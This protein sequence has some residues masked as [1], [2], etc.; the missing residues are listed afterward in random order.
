MLAFSLDADSIYNSSIVMWIAIITLDA[1]FS[2]DATDSRFFKIRSYLLLVLML[3]TL[4]PI[5]FMAICIVL[6][7]HT[8]RNIMG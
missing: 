3:I 4:D 8:I 2:K 6:L 7:E 5:I 1:V